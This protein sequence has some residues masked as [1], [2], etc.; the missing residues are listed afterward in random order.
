MVGG[1]VYFN[2]AGNGAVDYR[3]SPLDTAASPAAGPALRNTT[4]YKDRPSLECSQPAWDQCGSAISAAVSA[5][6]QKVR[7]ERF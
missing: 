1:S 5:C 4:A 2:L 6:E 7:T 3:R